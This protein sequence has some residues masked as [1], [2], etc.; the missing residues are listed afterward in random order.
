[1]RRQQRK[2][3][4][5]V[6]T[7]ARSVFSALN[8]RQGSGGQRAMATVLILYWLMR[9]SELDDARRYGLFWPV[10]NCITWWWG[11]VSEPHG[12]SLAR[13]IR[14]DDCQS[15]GM[16]QDYG[17]LC[18]NDM[19]L[20]TG[21]LPCEDSGNGNENRAVSNTTACWRCNLRHVFSMLIPNILPVPISISG[22]YH[23]F[24]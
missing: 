7:I 10:Y 16:H 3:Q 20:F 5:A 17:L 15:S 11:D 9:S 13:C 6:M 8:G 12:K 14:V 19:I 4:Q 1:M 21:T 22:V 23:W 24:C 18:N 2:R